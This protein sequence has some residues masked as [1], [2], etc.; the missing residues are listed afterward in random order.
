MSR[1]SPN[2]TA[3]F[4][5]GRNLSLFS[6]NFGAEGS[7]VVQGADIGHPIDDAQMPVFAEIAGVAG[8]KPAFGGPCLRRCAGVPMVFLE[9]PGRAHQDFALR[10]ELQLHASRSRSDRVQLDLAIAL[11]AQRGIRS[12]SIRRA[13]SD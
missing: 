1:P 9:Q 2:A 11:H 13:A 7:A 10:R 8:V 4:I 12:R 3:S 5:S 6:S